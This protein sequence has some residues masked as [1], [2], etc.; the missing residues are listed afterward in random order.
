MVINKRTNSRMTLD[1]DEA[2]LSELLTPEEH[3]A[4]DRLVA[5]EWARAQR[6][7]LIAKNQTRSNIHAKTT[8]EA[9]NTHSKQQHHAQAEIRQHL[10]AKGAVTIRVV[11]QRLGITVG[12]VRR[13]HTTGQL[14]SAGFVPVQYSRGKHVHLW[15]SE[16]IIRYLNGLR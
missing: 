10:L 7:T 6:K 3:A 2:S 1:V 15:T 14:P 9:A 11:A 16:T 12:G 5:A 8:A 13:L 4:Y